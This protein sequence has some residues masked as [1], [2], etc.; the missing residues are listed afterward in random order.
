MTLIVRTL[1]ER[2]VLVAAARRQREAAKTHAAVAALVAGPDFAPVPGCY[3]IVRC[4]CDCDH[5][6][7]TR[8][9][10]PRIADRNNA[11]TFGSAIS[12]AFA[13]HQWGAG[14]TVER[15]LPA[16]D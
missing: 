2:R 1:A 8:G 3:Y 6:V 10:H 9:R 12:A 5:Y 7:D 4:A 11:E 15:V 13:A 14:A 16:G